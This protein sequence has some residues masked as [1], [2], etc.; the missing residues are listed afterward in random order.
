MKKQKLT[1]L[2][3]EVL[4]GLLLGDGSLQWNE[5]KTTCRFRFTQKNYAYIMHVYKIFEEFVGTPPQL[6]TKTQVWYFNTLQSP[7]FRF[8]RQQ[9]YRPDGTKQVPRLIH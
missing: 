5:K 6:N 3:K 9:F 7:V 2:Q 8:Y 4:F 1:R